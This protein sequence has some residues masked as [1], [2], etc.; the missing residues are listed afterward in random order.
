MSKRAAEVPPDA[1]AG[2]VSAP[3]ASASSVVDTVEITP[4]GAGS[5]VGRSCILVSYK[6]KNVLLDCGIHPGLSGIASLPYFDDVDL[7]T[8]RGFAVRMRVCFVGAVGLGRVA[9]V[10]SCGRRV[11]RRGARAHTQLRH[12]RAPSPPARPRSFAART[13][14]PRAPPR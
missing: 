11:R 9:C 10:V 12:A 13:A 4:L 1:A 14:P 3:G 8:V 7:A 5:E 2:G 6:G